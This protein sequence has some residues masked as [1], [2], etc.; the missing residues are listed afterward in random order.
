M[1]KTSERRL[2]GLLLVLC[3]L[4]VYA[5]FAIFG[6]PGGQPGEQPGEQK[7]AVREKVATLHLCNAEDLQ[8]INDSWEP[9]AIGFSL[10][11]NRTWCVVPEPGVDVRYVAG[12]LNGPGV[13]DVIGV[14]LFKGGTVI[15]ANTDAR[16]F[17]VLGNAT[18]YSRLTDVGV[19]HAVVSRIE[20]AAEERLRQ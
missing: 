11:A 18:P 1:A 7:A 16:T 10:T 6:Q 17:N 14:W 4:F 20:R 13:E 3:G 9:E 15:G 12:A 8:V 2:N 5:G 19:D